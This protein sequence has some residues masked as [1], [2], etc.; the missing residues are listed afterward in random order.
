MT[1]EEDHALTSDETETP[2]PTLEQRLA[3]LKRL[4]AETERDRERLLRA[5]VSL[6]VRTDRPTDAVPYLHRLLATTEEPEEQAAHLLTLGQLSRGHTTEPQ[7]PAR[8]A[9]PGDDARSPPRGHNGGPGPAG[10]PGGVPRPRGAR[11]L[12]A[13]TSLSATAF[14][15]GCGMNDERTCR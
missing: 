6:H 14:M 4:L 3:G 1:D 5:L 13:V 2:P 7:G 11:A 15:P 8:P 9:S 10:H 12:G